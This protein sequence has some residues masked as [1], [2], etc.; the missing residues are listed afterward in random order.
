MKLPRGSS[1]MEKMKPDKKKLLVFPNDPLIAYSEKGEIKP[2][3][4]NPCNYFDEV[5]IVTFIDK[6]IDAKS[7]QTL[8]GTAKLFL[9]PMGNLKKVLCAF[10]QKKKELLALTKH[11]QPDM[12]RTFN[13]LFQGYFGTWLGKQ[14]NIPVVTSLH[15]DYR[16]MR[17]Y[18][19]K[20][21]GVKGVIQHFRK[22]F[23]HQTLFCIYS[24]LLERQVL[25]NSDAVIC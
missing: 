19:Y 22:V 20:L 6:E 4:Y 25:R 23:I 7:V 18:P 9:Y 3:Y 13:P 10:S 8:A 12:I 11:I 15:G 2:R 5:H 16:E 21:F 17:W 24:L 14:L 1:D